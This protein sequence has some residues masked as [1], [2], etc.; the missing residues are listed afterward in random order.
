MFDAF[1]FSL[2]IRS[3]Q[4]SPL[5][6]VSAQWDDVLPSLCYLLLLLFISYII[7]YNFGVV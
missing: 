7:C 3:V 4:A 5:D 2:S 6:A 1:T